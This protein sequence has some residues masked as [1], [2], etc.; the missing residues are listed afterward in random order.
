[1]KNYLT[2][3]FFNACAFVGFTKPKNFIDQ[4]YLETTAKVGS[5]V[6]TKRFSIN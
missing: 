5:L 3:A 2:A 1:M 4:P 6:Q